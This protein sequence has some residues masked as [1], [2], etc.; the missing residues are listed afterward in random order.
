M[1]YY[2]LNLQSCLQGI[3]ESGQGGFD[4]TQWLRPTVSSL[5]SVPESVPDSN[6][7]EPKASCPEG[8]TTSEAPTEAS[9]PKCPFSGQEFKQKE[10]TGMKK[11]VFGTGLRSCSAQNLAVTE[12][13][14]MLVLLCR[15]VKEIKMS[16]EE[17]D[18]HLA[19]TFPHPTGMPVQLVAR[20]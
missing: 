14:V 9:T 13:I 4:P 11:L 5:D 2:V 20:N 19:P 17:Q 8:Y 18:R 12:I 6:T 15:E 7:S 16:E 3:K 1:P 10:A